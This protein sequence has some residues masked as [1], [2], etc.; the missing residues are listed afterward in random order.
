[1]HKTCQAASKAG[2][3]GPCSAGL[4]PSGAGSAGQRLCRQSA[5]ELVVQGESFAKF[6]WN[7][8]EK[9]ADHGRKTAG[10]APATR[11]IATTTAIIFFCG[12]GDDMLKVGGIWVVAVR[13]RIALA[14]R[15]RTLSRPR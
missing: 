11:C 12:R 9:T 14:R 10:F 1:M 7:K 6:Y 8:P 13:N 4:S 5:G 3:A 2:S 15:I